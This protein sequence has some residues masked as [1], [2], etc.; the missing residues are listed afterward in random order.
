MV[1]LGASTELIFVDDGSTDGTSDTIRDVL[2]TSPRP[3][4][5]VRT[6]RYTPNQGKWR[7]VK[8][9]FDQATGEIV[10]IL[11]ADMTTHPEELLPLYEAF[12]TG[13]AEFINCTRLVYPMDDG[14]MSVL[15][16]IGNKVFTILVCLVMETRV[17]D[18]LCGTKAMFKDDYRHFVMGRDPWGDYDLLFGAAQQRLRLQELP[19]H[20]RARVAGTSKM[21]SMKHTINLLKMCWHGFWQVKT[22]VGFPRVEPVKK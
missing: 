21:N 2:K 8:T 9:G 19:V 17:S 16:F 20:Y 15:K 4:I 18:T 12:A 22:F 7:A 1:S 5:E 6:I 13:R 11:D 3:D 14:S 10:M